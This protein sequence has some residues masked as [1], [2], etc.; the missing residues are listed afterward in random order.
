MF[1]IN[2]RLTILKFKVFF[3]NFALLFFDFEINSFFKINSSKIDLRFE[4]LNFILIAKNC[5]NF[6]IASLKSI[7]YNEIIIIFKALFILNLILCFF[8]LKSIIYNDLIFY[9]FFFSSTKFYYNIFSN[10]TNSLFFS[11]N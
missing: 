3:S 6:S 4:N 5:F 11:R 9:F 10:L 2:S 1:Y 8:S 7:I